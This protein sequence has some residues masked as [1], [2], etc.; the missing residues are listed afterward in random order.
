MEKKNVMVKVEL[1]NGE[2]FSY[3]IARTHAEKNI[4]EQSKSGCFE[5]VK[6]T[7][8]VFHP[9]HSIEMIWFDRTALVD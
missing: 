6:E 9:L 5:E 7:I 1:K 8:T 2:S 3:K 4:W